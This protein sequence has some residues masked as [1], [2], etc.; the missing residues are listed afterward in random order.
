M[1]EQPKQLDTARMMR[2]PSYGYMT[3]RQCGLN[4]EQARPSCVECPLRIKVVRGEVPT[5]SMHEYLHEG[6][7]PGAD[8][9]A[10]PSTANPPPARTAE[11]I[12]LEHLSKRSSAGTTEISAVL[13]HLPVASVLRRLEDMEQEGKI[14]KRVA[15]GLTLW[16]LP[17]K[18]PQGANGRKPSK[19]ELDVVLEWLQA[20]PGE[21]SKADVT[22]GTRLNSGSVGNYLYHLHRSKKIKRTGMRG[23]YGYSALPAEQ[24]QDGRGEPLEREEPAVTPGAPT[25]PPPEPEVLEQQEPKSTA[26]CQQESEPPLPPI[27]PRTRDPYAEHDANLPAPLREDDRPPAGELVSPRRNLAELEQQV[28]AVAADVEAMRADALMKLRLADALPPYDNAWP[29][30][31]KQRFWRIAQFVLEERER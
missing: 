22:E 30:H 3:L 4:H 27:N 9:V 23:Q 10:A 2:C 12:I 18:E 7:R 29:E 5:V 19:R 17:G 11:D 28:N 14:T 1:A 8:E 13:K 6:K 21:H 31:V 15:S 24:R 20:N 16:S 26:D 25:T